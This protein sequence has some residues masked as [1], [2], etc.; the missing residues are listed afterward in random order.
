[1]ENLDRTQARKEGYRQPFTENILS[2]LLRH[3]TLQFKFQIL[4]FVLIFFFFFFLI[5]FC[6]SARVSAREP[7]REGPALPPALLSSVRYGLARIR[8]PRP[9]AAQLSLCT[10]ENLVSQDGPGNTF[11]VPYT[12]LSTRGYY[13]LR[14][15]TRN[16][17]CTS[18]RPC[19]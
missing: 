6:A 12:I 7:A 18:Y 2:R 16:R 10:P 17:Y 1:M 14:E 13:I 4:I 9:R 3:S 5:I 8:A 19:A 11:L 15:G